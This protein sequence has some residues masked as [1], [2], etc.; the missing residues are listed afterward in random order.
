MVR[1]QCGLTAANLSSNVDGSAFGKTLS[2]TGMSSSMNGTIT[3]TANGMS[4]N[5]SCVVRFSYTWHERGVRCRLRDAAYL[6][7]L[8][9]R[10]ALAMEQLPLQPCGDAHLGSKQLAAVPVMLNL[11][12]DLLPHASG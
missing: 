3:K 11:V 1:R 6:P 8:S 12:L 10:Q 7:A 9:P 5:R 4:R 2:T